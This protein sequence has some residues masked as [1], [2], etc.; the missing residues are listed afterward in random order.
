MKKMLLFS[1]LALFLGLLVQ[2]CKMDTEARVEAEA[3]LNS[4]AAGIAGKVESSSSEIKQE[5]KAQRDIINTTQNFT[6]E[7][8]EAIKSANRTN[9]WNSTVALLCVLGVAVTLIISGAVVVCVVFNRM[10][11]KAENDARDMGGRLQRALAILP[12]SEADKVFPRQ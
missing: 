2:G 3:R 1:V 7:V 9:A 4:T 10:R 8:L 6:K 11:V 12:P 5:M